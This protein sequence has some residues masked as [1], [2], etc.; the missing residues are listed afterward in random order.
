MVK[1]I[2]LAIGAAAL[3]LTSVSATA[4][5]NDK[6]TGV[7]GAVSVGVTDA[8]QRNATYGASVGI[9]VPVGPVVTV[10][11]EASAVNAFDDR[12]RQFGTA[13]R[14]GVAVHPN[15]LVF[16]KGGYTHLNGAGSGYQVGGGV[17]HS[18]TNESFVRFQ[19][20]WSDFDRGV[21]AKAG[22]VSVG[23]RF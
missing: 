9:D 21:T 17:E 15:L 6:F 3:A 11:V 5:V 7:N 20:D 14:L 16:A 12:D 8:G 19:Y 10:G 4:N 23:Y 2:V 13:A 22:A 18:I 1:N